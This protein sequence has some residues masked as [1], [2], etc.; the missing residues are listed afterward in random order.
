MWDHNAHMTAPF[1]SG[2]LDSCRAINQQRFS[3]LL[4]QNQ[5][6]SCAP[7]FHSALKLQPGLIVIQAQAE[8]LYVAGD[9]FKCHRG[10]SVRPLLALYCLYANAHAQLF[11]IS[12]LNCWPPLKLSLSVCCLDVFDELLACSTA[13][14]KVKAPYIATL[15]S[16]TAGLRHFSLCQWTLSHELFSDHTRLALCHLFL[17]FLISWSK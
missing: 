9:C 4:S 13:H 1:W 17:Y 3:V 7:F 12:S 8:A 16:S 15:I 14:R 2:H 6:C 10:P 11:F 5:T